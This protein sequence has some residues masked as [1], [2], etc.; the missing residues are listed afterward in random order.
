MTPAAKAVLAALTAELEWPVRRAVEKRYAGMSSE[1]EYLFALKHS[2]SQGDAEIVKGEGWTIDR[3]DVLCALNSFYQIV[4]GPQGAASRKWRA[5]AFGALE[6][7]H[8]SSRF[9]A[10]RAIDTRSMIYEFERRFARLGFMSDVATAPTAGAL[11]F[12]LA[13]RFRE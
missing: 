6:V 8:G 12:R 7:V 3:V 5:T 4:L 9:D 11:L 2:Q 1:L 10:G 13:D